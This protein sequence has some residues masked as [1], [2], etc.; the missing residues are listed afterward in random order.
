M[1]S[2]KVH[3]RPTWCYPCR[4]SAEQVNWAG[5]SRYGER[6]R[7]MKENQRSSL[8]RVTDADSANNL[9]FQCRLCTVPDA[10]NFCTRIN[11]NLGPFLPYSQA[12]SN[13]FSFSRILT[14]PL[15]TFRSCSARAIAQVS[16]LKSG[17]LS[18]GLVTL[19]LSPHIF[20]GKEGFESQL[21]AAGGRMSSQKTNNNDS[22]RDG[23]RLSAIK[24]AKKYVRPPF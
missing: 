4:S 16:E 12:I 7:K 2:E 24:E 20:S 17:Q 23:Q 21:R 3:R 14:S 1:I 18:G 8:A 10:H 11:G 13:L 9:C 5:Q 19:R 6:I 15:S 22:C